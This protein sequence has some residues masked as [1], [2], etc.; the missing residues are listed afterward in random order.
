MPVRNIAV[1]VLA[2]G[3]SSRMGGEPKQLLRF[4]GK[5]MV[6]RAVDTA[7]ETACGPVI[8]VLGAHAGKVYAELAGTNVTFAENSDWEAGMGTSIAA[9]IAV[10]DQKGCSGAI[11]ALVDQP[12]VTSGMLRRLLE[13]HE[14]TGKPIVASEYAGTAGVPVLFERSFFG[15]LQV[16]GASHG[17]KNLILSNSEQASFIQCPE[18]EIDID[19]PAEHQRQENG[20]QDLLSGPPLK[21]AAH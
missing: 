2:A 10:A 9:G 16:L 17:C 8:V 3:A 4:R 6:R 14:L 15:R 13:E 18:A 1:V 20:S 5:T 19:T 7:L 21:R 11:L 12:F